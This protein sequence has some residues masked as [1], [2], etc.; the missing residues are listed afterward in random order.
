M[1]AGSVRIVI[2]PNRIRVVAL[3]MKYTS[4]WVKSVGWSSGNRKTVIA[5]PRAVADAATH[6]HCRL[7]G[8]NRAPAL[9]VA[10]P[11]RAEVVRPPR[12][13]L[14]PPP[15]AGPSAGR[16]PATPQSRPGRQV[17][18]ARTGHRA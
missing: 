9:R 14:L 1:K 10:G 12:E 13:A 11:I 4:P 17:R 8:G 7:T 16:I 6:R 18:P 3:P 2:P 15:V 5:H